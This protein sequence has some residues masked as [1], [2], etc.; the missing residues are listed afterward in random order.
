MEDIQFNDLGP[1]RDLFLYF[2][3]AGGII[4]VLVAFFTLYYSWKYRRRKND[5]REPEQSYGSKKVELGL[6]GVAFTLTAVF[7][8]LSI[9]AM[10]EIQDIPEDP[11]P[12][13]IITGHQWWWEAQ[14]TD[15]GLVTANEIHVPAGEKILIQFNSD[16]V[17]HSWWIPTLGRKMDL[18]PGIDN[19]LNLQ[20]KKE[21]EYWGSCS[22]F[23]G[24]QH[25]WMRIRLIAHSPEEFAK[26]KN[27]KLKIT[28]QPTDSLFRQGQRLFAT[29]TCT[30]CHA[31]LPTVDSPDV[32]PNLAHFA[33]RDYFLSNVRKNT[34]D[35]LKEWLR[36]PQKVKSSAKMPNMFLDDEELTALVHYLENLK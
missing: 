21:G 9:N 11:K 12:D 33:S 5:N 23:C 2:L 7:F 35:N 13:L 14:Y 17:I 8:V 10:N 29:K 28:P 19:Y 22:E 27:E 1:I 4:L 16:D 30:N 6:I 20:V 31:I 18:V 34:R 36:N 15:S 25:G 24:V 26:W 3:I 32:G